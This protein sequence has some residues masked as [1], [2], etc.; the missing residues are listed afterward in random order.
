MLARAD[1]SLRALSSPTVITATSLCMTLG[2]HYLGVTPWQA[3]AAVAYAGAFPLSQI[4]G[5]AASTVCLFL[6]APFLAVGYI[7][8][9]V[10]VAVLRIEAAYPFGLFCAVLVQ[11]WCLLAYWNKGSRGNHDAAGD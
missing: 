1:T 10:S 7:V 11:V 5:G 2:K 9:L 3:M 4:V 6:T 8:G